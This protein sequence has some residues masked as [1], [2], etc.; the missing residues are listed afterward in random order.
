MTDQKK[1]WF[2]RLTEGLSKTTK[3]LTEQVVATFVET[4]EPLDEAK[5]DELEESLIEADL[6]PAAAAR[7]RE[8]FAELAVEV[9]QVALRVADGGQ[10]DVG[11][12]R[13]A[14]RQHPQGHALARAGIAVDQR[15]AALAHLS[16]LDAPAKALQ[17][18]RP[19]AASP[20]ARRRGR[21]RTLRQGHASAPAP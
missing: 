16:V 17:P 5:L 4:K 14:L 21:P 7:I 9:G 1:G 12:P 11:Q 13:Q 19:S 3:Q 20:R 2:S 8:R 6:G 10:L 18:G 15:E